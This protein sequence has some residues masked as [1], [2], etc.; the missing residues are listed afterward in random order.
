MTLED[1]LVHRF[2]VTAEWHLPLRVSE[3]PLRKSPFVS[4]AL[5]VCLLGQFSLRFHRIIEL[6]ALA[7]PARIMTTMTLLT[8]T[9]KNPHP[10][11]NARESGCHMIF[12][13]TGYRNSERL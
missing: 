7:L 2:P 3:T 6:C 1:C 10:A 11:L 13:L 12:A 9:P 5:S 4:R 8:P